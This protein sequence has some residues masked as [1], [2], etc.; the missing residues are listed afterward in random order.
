MRV[1]SFPHWWQVTFTV[2]QGV[3][4]V[5]AIEP[6]CEKTVDKGPVPGV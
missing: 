1:Q 4:T 5:R 6:D 2:A 3:L